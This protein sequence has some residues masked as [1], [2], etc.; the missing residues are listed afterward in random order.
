MKSTNKHHHYLI[1]LLREDKFLSQFRLWFRGDWLI[2][3]LCLKIIT[4]KNNTNKGYPITNII[5]LSSS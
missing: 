2:L 3:L 5:I 4:S 1:K